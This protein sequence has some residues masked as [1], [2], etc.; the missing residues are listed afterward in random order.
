MPDVLPFIGTAAYHL[1]RVEAA[2]ARARASHAP[3]RDLLKRRKL[4]VARC[5]AL[6]G[7]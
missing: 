7:K 4:L 1:A 3:C 6:G 2:I 5:A